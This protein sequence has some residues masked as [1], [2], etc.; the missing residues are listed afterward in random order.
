MSFLARRLL[1]WGSL[2]RA[3]KGYFVRGGKGYHRTKSCH[4]W[5]DFQS[6]EVYR[7][8]TPTECVLWGVEKCYCRF[9]AQW[10]VF[11]WA[12]TDLAQQ[13]EY[14]HQSECVVYRKDYCR[15]I[16]H[17]IWIVWYGKMDRYNYRYI[18]IFGKQAVFENKLNPLFNSP[19]KIDLKTHINFLRF[20]YMFFLTQKASDNYFLSTFWDFVHMELLPPFTKRDTLPWL[21]GFTTL[22]FFCW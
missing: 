13:N 15:F 11:V 12:R 10:I 3:W 9:N 22:A 1:S 4:N 2:V 19:F 14:L 16:L 7:F 6:R 20:Y 8:G 18:I 5:V 17:W 21:Q